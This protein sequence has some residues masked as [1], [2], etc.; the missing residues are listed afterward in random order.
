MVRHRRPPSRRTIAPAPGRGEDAD[1]PPP[2]FGLPEDFA[3]KY[4]LGKKLGEGTF[5][6]AYEALP[7]SGPGMVVAVKI[8]PKSMLQVRSA[9][10]RAR[11]GSED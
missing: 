8:I 3:A 5:G 11:G 7:K 6:T 2:Q 4:K 10:A 9:A 1:L